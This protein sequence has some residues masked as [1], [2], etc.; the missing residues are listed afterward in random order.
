[1]R[2]CLLILAI[3]CMGHDV[4]A[5]VGTH[6]RREYAD[7]NAPEYRNFVKIGSDTTD[8]TFCTGQFVAPN[9]ILTAYHCVGDCTAGNDSPCHIT[10]SDGQREYVRMVSDFGELTPLQ[11]SFQHYKSPTNEDMAFLRPINEN[12]THDTFFDMTSKCYTGNVFNAGFGNMRILSDAE[13]SKIHRLYVDMLKQRD[14]ISYSKGRTEFGMTEDEF[15][16]HLTYYDNTEVFRSD[17]LDLDKILQEN[18]V[19]KIFEDTERFKVDK[20]C[21]VT[22]CDE[23]RGQNTC[24]VAPG[25]SGGA[26]VAGNVLAGIM[27]RGKFYIGTDVKNPSLHVTPPALYKKYKKIMKHE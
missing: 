13:I 4:H 12:Y 7:W 14:W 15:K 10:T 18:N 3:M 21:V 23:E 8:A 19:E 6:D 16:S 11:M 20:V 9:L 24:I 17:T 26:L 22:Q 25:N 27:S 2:R 5:N 1:M